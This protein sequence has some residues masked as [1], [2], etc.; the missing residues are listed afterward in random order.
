MLR[1]VACLLLV[2]APTAV[3]SQLR[4][5]RVGGAGVNAMGQQEEVQ[6]DGDVDLGSLAA[7]AGMEGLDAFKDMDLSKLSDPS[8]MME[9]L[10]NMDPSALAENPMLK[11]MAAA[12]PELAGILNNPE[13][14]KEKMQEV[15]KM[16][17]SEEGQ[18]MAQKMM[19]EMGNVLSDPEKLQQ[20]LEQLKDNPALKGLAS[21]V[22]GLEDMLNN[23]EQLKEQVEKTAEMFGKFQDP[24]Q[25]QELLSAAG[26]MEGI[27]ASMKQMLDAMGGEGDALKE[28]MAGLGSAGEGGTDSLKDRVDRLMQEAGMGEQAAEIEDEF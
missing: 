1:R 7:G 18:G 19:E 8:A 26:G 9:A 24:E 13:L 16:M 6:Q 20:G 15:A 22:P 2:L 21:A 5:R 3:M 27:Q 25:M 11:S 10:G 4:P 28:M 23:P 14:M 17:N 12:S